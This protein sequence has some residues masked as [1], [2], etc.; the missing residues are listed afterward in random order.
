MT[1]EAFRQDEQAVFQMGEGFIEA[2]SGTKRF[3][4]VR[5]AERF[6]SNG[7]KS[8]FPTPLDW[9]TVTEICNKNQTDALL[10]IEIFDTDFI[11]TNSPVKI[12]TRKIGGR[13]VT[14]PVVQGKWRGSNQRGHP[15]V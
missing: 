11:L 9:N 1:G 4:T 10:S 5:T 15:F 14:L 6:T 8:T 3:V 12:E 7:T 13:M 2:C